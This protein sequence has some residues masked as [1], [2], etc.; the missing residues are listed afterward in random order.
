[1]RKVFADSS[2]LI[3]GA[4]SRGEASRAVLT[5]AEI[6]LFKLIVSRQ[7]LDECERNLRK[8]LPAAL[9]LFAE[10]LAAINL[11]IVA[12][13]P[14]E[15]ISRWESLI[16]AKDAPI[17]AVAVLAAPDR[18]L[19]LNPKDFTLTVAAQSGLLIQSPG[20]FVQEIR[21]IIETGL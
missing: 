11:E 16:E 17:L 20:E 14:A 4:S 8:K 7:V 18:L 3:A 5:M 13:P 19:T 15:E 6:G 2:V 12:D 21:A 1:M 10:L 9:P